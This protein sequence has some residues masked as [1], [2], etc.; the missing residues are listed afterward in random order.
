M[1]PSNVCAH[2]LRALAASKLIRQFLPK[3]GVH[4]I[5][6]IPSIDEIDTDQMSKVIAF[7]GNLKRRAE[8]LSKLI[9]GQLPPTTPGN[10]DNP[11][12]T[13]TTDNPAGGGEGNPDDMGGIP[14]FEG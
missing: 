9:T 7:L 12:D 4:E 3:L 6:E 2:K 14:G 11:I 5:A 1:L 10:G 8:D 13:T